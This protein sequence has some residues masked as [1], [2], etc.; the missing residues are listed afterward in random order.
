MRDESL[1]RL[2]TELFEDLVAEFSVLRPQAIIN[3]AR[4]AAAVLSPIT[5]KNALRHAD[6]APAWNLATLHDGSATHN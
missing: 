2:A 3:A 4:I 1:Q 6:L 5:D